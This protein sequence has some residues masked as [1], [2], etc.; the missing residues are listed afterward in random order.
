ME[1]RCRRAES[2]PG[3][4]SLRLVG[5]RVD[6]AVVRLDCACS[7]GGRNAIDLCGAPAA[8]RCELSGLLGQC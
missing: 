7:L 5:R 3:G 1:Q 4:D 6:V 8:N 2:V